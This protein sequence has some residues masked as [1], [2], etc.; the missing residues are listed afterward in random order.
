VSDIFLSYAREDL[1]V[2]KRLAAAFAARGWSVWWDQRLPIGGPFEKLTEEELARAGCVVVLWSRASVSS[3]WV[4]SEASEARE[5]RVLFP[6]L[7]EDVKPPL[8]FRSLQTGTLIGWSGDTPH[9]GFEQLVSDMARWLREPV[10]RTPLPVFV[11]ARSRV[12][13]WTMVMSPTLV[14]ALVVTL[15]SVLRVATSISLAL[16][17]QRVTFS[18]ADGDS[19]LV[20]ILDALAFPASRYSLRE[21]RYP[22]TAW[23]TLAQR[24]GSLRFEALEARLLPS[25]AI[26]RLSDTG[27]SLGALGPIT[28]P[29]GSVVTLELG[30]ERGRSVTLR[31]SHAQPALA[32]PMQGAAL[33][34]ATGAS[35]K[36]DDDVAAASQTSTWRVDF[37][38]GAAPVAVTGKSGEV[39]TSITL[40]ATP[41]DGSLPLF[42]GGSIPVAV[43]DF[44]TQDALGQRVSSVVGD[45]Q[46]LFLDR[47]GA[48][49]Q[50]IESSSV[51]TLGGL[52][53]FSIR[54]VSVDPKMRSLRMELDGL[55]DTVTTERGP[56]RV[57]HRQTALAAAMRHPLWVIFGVF[58][59]LL[60]TGAVLYRGRAAA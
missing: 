2:A 21:D 11:P 43:I 22:D 5:R 32:I 26:E 57:D 28:L 41:A 37:R 52:S 9:E 7:I 49:R 59:W 34:T 10:P 23:K 31:V 1:E 17:V 29:T 3:D 33:L 6:V 55:V 4:K 38:E 24:V 27:G 45:G 40:P 25:L 53:Q 19:S 39:I 54:R 20:R 14:A 30:E 47:P 60:A 12:L 44:S 36:A 46:L 51:V 13:A 8:E 42:S 48:M 58:V 15:L 18:I 16:P 56:L 50:V 35:V